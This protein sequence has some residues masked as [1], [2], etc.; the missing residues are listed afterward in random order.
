MVGLGSQA[1]SAVQLSVSCWQ[2]FPKGSTS[3]LSL[4]S[5]LQDQQREEPKHAK[6]YAFLPVSNQN[7]QHV[8]SIKTTPCLNQ[9][10]RPFAQRK[11]GH[12]LLIMLLRNNEMVALQK[13]NQVFRNKKSD[14]HWRPIKRP[15]VFVIIFYLADSFSHCLGFFLHLLTSGIL[16]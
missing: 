14:L 4:A 3:P 8:C 16:R 12:F 6:V 13:H 11:Y 5:L 15:Q 2:S 1:H 9:C 7:C 10:A